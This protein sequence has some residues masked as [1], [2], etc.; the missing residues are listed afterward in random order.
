MSDTCSE[1]L[2][3]FLDGVCLSNEAISSFQ[4]RFYSSFTKR[5]KNKALRNKIRKIADSAKF[6][7]GR[8]SHKG[9]SGEKAEKVKDDRI[10]KTAFNWFKIGPVDK[11]NSKPRPLLKRSINYLG[12]RTI[13]FYLFNTIFF[14]R[15]KT[16][17][18]LTHK[19]TKT[20]MKNRE[21]I[22]VD[23]D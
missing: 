22:I 10:C 12:E 7:R 21:K 18:D 11:V 4:E 13:L 8:G 23:L 3:K 6:S 15:V 14:D 19:L 9:K 1:Y 20:Y 5:I 17:R 16:G 2:P